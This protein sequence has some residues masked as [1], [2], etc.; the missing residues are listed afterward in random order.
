[1]WVATIHNKVWIDSLHG[2]GYMVMWIDSLHAG[3]V[4]VGV[5]RDNNK[6]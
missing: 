6:V 1:M 5:G 4:F 2:H 3:V